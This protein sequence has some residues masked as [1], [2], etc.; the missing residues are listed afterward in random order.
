MRYR[1]CITAALAGATGEQGAK[2][3][4]GDRGPSNAYTRQKDGFGQGPFK[5]TLNLKAGNYVLIARATAVN[6]KQEG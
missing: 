5:Y 1:K 3:E 4:K 6:G 2:G